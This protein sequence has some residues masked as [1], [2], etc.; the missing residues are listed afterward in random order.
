MVAYPVSMTP[1][2]SCLHMGHEILGGETAVVHANRQLPQKVCPQHVVTGRNQTPQQIA[3]LESAA[4]SVET[5]SSLLNPG[6]VLYWVLTAA[7]S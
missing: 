2:M 4:C 5:N 3:H 1:P 6:I 7:W